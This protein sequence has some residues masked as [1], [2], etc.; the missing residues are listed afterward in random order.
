[1]TENYVSNQLI[2]NGYSPYYWASERGAEIDFIIQ[3]ENQ[4]IPIEIKAAD[5]LK[6]KSLKRY[7]EL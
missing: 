2:V 1:M 4:I 7:M 5:N 3:R 6:A